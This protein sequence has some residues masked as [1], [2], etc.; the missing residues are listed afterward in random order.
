LRQSE[1]N[2]E[3]KS[4]LDIDS[5]ILEAYTI[6]FLYESIEKQFHDKDVCQRAMHMM[7]N[8]EQRIYTGNN[9]I[10]FHCIEFLEMTK[11]GL[12]ASVG[13]LNH[14][15]Y[16]GIIDDGQHD[17]IFHIVNDA[18]KSYAI[19][20]EFIIIWK[21]P[22]LL[23]SMS[24]LKAAALNQKN[25]ELK[26][27]KW[28]TLLEIEAKFTMCAQCGHV[29]HSHKQCKRKFCIQC[30]RFNH[31]KRDCIAIKDKMGNRLVLC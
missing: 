13:S 24:K 10:G 4:W 8:I 15:L 25:F 18:K 7:Y 14:D 17:K 2:N 9:L 1:L 11:Y 16:I 28:P 12:L 20:R 22:F 26:D 27:C 31:F 30:L 29:G 23:K 19:E 3:I 6:L 21:A 5:C